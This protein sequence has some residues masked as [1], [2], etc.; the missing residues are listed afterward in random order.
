MLG[1]WPAVCAA[2]AVRPIPGSRQAHAHFLGS[3]ATLRL[4]TLGTL[5]PAFRLAA[6]GLAATLLLAGGARA[7]GECRYTVRDVGAAAPPRLLSVGEIDR[8]L[9]AGV[10][11]LT[12]HGPHDLRLVFDGAA[13]RQLPRDASEPAHGTLPPGVALRSVECLPA[14]SVGDGTPERLARAAAIAEHGPPR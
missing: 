9:P 6:F 2:R 13:P 11:R 8:R 5:M 12:N 10:Q 3:G 14:R 7:A 4:A 1:T